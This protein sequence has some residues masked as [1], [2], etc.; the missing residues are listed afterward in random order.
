MN[1]SDASAAARLV[2]YAL[3]P[4]NRPTPASEY[5]V[6]LDRFRTDTEFE[7]DVRTI[8]EG[9]GLFV[10]APTPLG[11]I[12]TGDADGPFR[13][14]L[15]NC[16]LPLRSGANRLV[17]RRCFGLVLT[18]LAAFAYPNGEALAE[19]TSP[20]VRPAELE[21]FITRHA[22]SLAAVAV[23][24]GEQA[25]ELDV[26][27]AEAAKHWLDLPEVLPS[28]RGGYRRECRRSYVLSSLAFLVETGRARRDA[29][30]A[31]DRGEAY[32][33]NDRFRAGLLEV[34]ET[35]AFEVFAADRA[36]DHEEESL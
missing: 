21:R 17:D 9:L 28:E 8:A 29:A 36:G 7:E 33:L 23:D 16:G 11:L 12:L 27:L 5:R 3:V 31:D 6:L 20:T 32:T 1:R 25:D 26:Q 4:A 22:T 18:A 30:L 14:T 2:R 24:A 34:A 10:R 13:V 19:T 35:L 15:D